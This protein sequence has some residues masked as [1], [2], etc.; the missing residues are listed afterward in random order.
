MAVLIPAEA[1]PPKANG[2]GLESAKL[3]RP[4]QKLM[5][6]W[7]LVTLDL[8]VLIAAFGFSYLL[9]FDFAIPRKEWGPGLVQVLLAVAPSAIGVV[10]HRG[11]QSSSGVNIGLSE[12]G[13]F[14]KAA[15]L[16]AVPLILLRIT[17]PQS[18]SAGRVPHLGHHCRYHFSPSAER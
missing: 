1:P 15:L 14:A 10:C 12:L 17:L 6:K 3:P 18:L 13:A 11:A 2:N 4:F 7:G 8:L 5:S 16:S 9:R